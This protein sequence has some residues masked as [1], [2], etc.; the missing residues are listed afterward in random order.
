MRR[1]KG[2]PILVCDCTAPKGWP[3]AVHRRGAHEN[4]SRVRVS[5]SEMFIKCFRGSIDEQGISRIT[6]RC[7]QCNR[8]LDMRFPVLDGDPYCDFFECRKDE[9]QIITPHIRFV[10]PYKIALDGDLPK[11]P[12]TLPDGAYVK[13]ERS[14]EGT[15]W[16]IGF[17]LRWVKGIPSPRGPKSLWVDTRVKE[18]FITIIDMVMADKFPAEELPDWRP[19]GSNEQFN[20][21]LDELRSSYNRW[22]RQNNQGPIRLEPRISKTKLTKIF[23]SKARCVR[24]NLLQEWKESGDPSELE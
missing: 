2:E 13:E 14:G 1:P 19:E 17:S 4:G 3:L 10:D 15:Y 7:P 6:G 9:V 22:R 18:D 21:W 11:H 16:L 20:E 23:G 24:E 8:F 5:G 12:S